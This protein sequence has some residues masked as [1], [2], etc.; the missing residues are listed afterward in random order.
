MPDDYLSTAKDGTCNRCKLESMNPTNSSST[1][2]VFRMDLQQHISGDKSLLPVE[3]K[4]NLFINDGSHSSSFG[5]VLSSNRCLGTCTSIDSYE[6]LGTLG[7]GGLF[8]M[9]L[10]ILI[11]T[12]H[13]LHS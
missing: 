7:E 13:S 4:P 10:I 6:N 1:E 5:R 2:R 12:I 3:D 8:S 11:C 9:I